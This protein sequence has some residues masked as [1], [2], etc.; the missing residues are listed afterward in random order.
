MEFAIWILQN[1]KV[2]ADEVEYRGCMYDYNS[3]SDMDLLYKE[4]ELKKY[5]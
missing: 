1:C 5:R 3:V 4:Y 2:W